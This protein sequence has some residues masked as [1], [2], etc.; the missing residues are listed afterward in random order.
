MPLGMIAGTAVNAGLGLGLQAINNSVQIDQQRKLSEQQLGFDKRRAAYGNELALQ[1]W[2]DTNYAAQKKEMKA[3]ELSPGLMYGGGGAGGGTVGSGQGSVSAPDAAKGGGE[4]LGLMMMDAQ[5]ALIEA[6]TENV[7]ADTAK[8]SGVD[9]ELVKQQGRI[10]ENAA[11]FA[12]NTYNINYGKLMDEW[13]KVSNEAEIARNNKNISNETVDTEVKMKQA[14]LIG[15]GLA[16]ELKRAQ[17]D[18]TEQQ[19]VATAESIAQK[20]REVQVK[21]GHLDLDRFIRDVKESTKLTTET[22]MK[23]IS[24]LK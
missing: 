10:A 17:K 12:K 24:V 18:L 4:A 21:E 14:E 5:R 2:K 22:I 6:Q 15:L 20:W 7:K 9:T 19:I 1:M 23:V 3:A 16:N 11:D 8:K 13:E